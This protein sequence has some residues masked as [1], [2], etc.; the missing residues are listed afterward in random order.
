M[1]FLISLAMVWLLGRP[2]Q[3]QHELTYGLQAATY[4]AGALIASPP[5]PMLYM[6]S[7]LKHFTV[8]PGY[9]EG[10]IDYTSDSPTGQFQTIGRFSGGGGAVAFDHALTDTVG[11]FM[12]AMGDS[13]GG[14]FTYRGVS[15]CSPLCNETGLK[16]IKATF[17]TVA[18]GINWTF[19]GGK[20]EQVFSAGVFAGPAVTTAALSQRVVA[21]NSSGTV[22]DDFNMKASPTFATVL[23]GLQLGIA[24]GDWLVLNPYALTNGAINDDPCINYEVTSQAVPGTLAGKSTPT[25]GGASN[26]GTATSDHKID[27]KSSALS[28]VGLNIKFPKVGLALNAYSVPET[29]SD[30]T[31]KALKINAY[32]LSLSFG[33]GG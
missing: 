33:S 29:P 13:V 11:Y 30:V 6:K 27:I 5:L 26:G 18:T 3:A 14:D 15:G 20:P 9:V 23:L 32:S 22:T 10:S 2:A 19:W 1:G 24:V 31:M 12:M 25:C 4:G 17:A 8:Q 16:D 21:S 7:G 28:A